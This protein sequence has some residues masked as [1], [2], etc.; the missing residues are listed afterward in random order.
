MHPLLIAAVLIPLGILLLVFAVK[1]GPPAVEEVDDDDILDE[2]KDEADET[3]VPKITSLAAPPAPPTV[4][5]SAAR[6]P[7]AKPADKPVAVTP[8]KGDS[9]FVPV[10]REA[11]KQAATTSRSVG[12]LTPI[13]R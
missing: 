1:S 2:S 11:V 5:M 8:K 6:P 4:M 12:K 10:L 7:V 9:A 13:G 3:N